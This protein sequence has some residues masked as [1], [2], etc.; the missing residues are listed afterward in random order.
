MIGG[1]YGGRRLQFPAAM[2]LR[3]T[4]DRVRETLFN[5]LQQDIAKSRCLDLFA[6]S[7]A[8][9]FEAVSRGAAR[10][11]MIESQRNVFRSLQQNSTLLQTREVVRL[12]NAD[13]LRWLQGDAEMYQ[14]VFVD[15]PFNRQLMQPVIDQLEHGG[16]L[17]PEA[18]IYLEQD[19]HEDPPKLPHSWRIIR[20]KTAGQVR[21]QLVQRA[22]T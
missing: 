21:Y 8:L 1:S 9:G 11:T 10:V 12:I 4:A 14:L 19:V 5:W 17:V 22:A 6:G 13:A 18:L 16:W 2:G 20:D 15:P 3:P 7:G